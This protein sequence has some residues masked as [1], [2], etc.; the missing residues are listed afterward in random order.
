MKKILMTLAAVLCCSMTTTVFTACGGDDDGNNTNTPPQPKAVAIQIDYS[1]EFPDTVRV[2]APSGDSTEINGNL[3]LLSKKMEIG[4]I[5]ENGKA[6]REEIKNKKWSKTVTYQYRE[7]FET[8]LMLYTTRLDSIDTASLPY[9][10]YTNAISVKPTDET[11]ITIIFD[12]GTKV[13]PPISTRT[14][15]SVEHETAHPGRKNLQTWLESLIPEEKNI[16]TLRFL[17]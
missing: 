14:L 8:N 6:Q 5:D 1:V 11:G 4:Y 17:Y 9:V 10:K 12:D 13:T 3:Y 16:M 2:L 15:W 7:K